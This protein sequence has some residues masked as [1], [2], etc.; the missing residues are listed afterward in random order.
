MT[1]KPHFNS[2]WNIQIKDQLGNDLNTINQVKQTYIENYTHQ[3]QNT[4]SSQTKMEHSPGQNTLGTKNP[5]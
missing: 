3:E 4:H 2:G 5:Q 1:P